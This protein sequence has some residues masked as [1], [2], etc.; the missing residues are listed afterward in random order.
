MPVKDVCALLLGLGIAVALAILAQQVR[1]SSDDAMR[2]EAGVAVGFAALISLGPFWI[3]QAVLTVLATLDD[4]GIAAWWLWVWL[5][6][7]PALGVSS[8]ATG[9]VRAVRHA[10]A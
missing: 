10:L 3:A 5:F 7:A 6:L 9:L 2:W 8:P 1:D 4:V